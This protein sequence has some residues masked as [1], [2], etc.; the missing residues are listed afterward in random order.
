MIGLPLLCALLLSAPPPERA[1]LDAL[2]SLPAT[3]LGTQSLFRLRYGG[4]EGEGS[5]RLTLRLAS[6]DHYRVT[7][8]DA[9]GR[10]VWSLSVEGAGGLWIDHKERRYCR[11][12]GAEQ[13]SAPALAPFSL[14]SLPAILFGRLPVSAVGELSLD[15]DALEFRDAAARRWT[16]RREGDGLARWTLW[17]EAEPAIWYGLQGDEAVLSERAQ[18]IQLRWRRVVS[19]PLLELPPPL[20]PPEGYAESCQTSSNPADLP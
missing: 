16:A 9:V 18:G 20:T 19:E 3:A 4:P 17:S 12:E 1:S 7:T 11:F 14:P 2:W 6:P 5:F 8:V 13:I 15:G 10:M